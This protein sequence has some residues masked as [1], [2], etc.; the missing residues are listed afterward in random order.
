MSRGRWMLVAEDNEDDFLLI[1][2]A[3]KKVDPKIEVRR[4]TDGAEAL[5]ILDVSD[6]LPFL[7]LLDIK[8]PRVSGLQVLERL[9]ANDRTKSVPA[10]ILTSSDEP[11]DVVN[12]YRFG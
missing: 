8:M 2:R 10:V 4:G 1:S 5:A 9:R 7:A 11:T 6:T 12:A 3:M